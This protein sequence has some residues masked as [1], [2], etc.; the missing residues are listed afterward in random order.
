MEDFQSLLQ[1]SF[2]PSSRGHVGLEREYKTGLSQTTRLIS[3]TDNFEYHKI[4]L[5]GLDSILLAE[6]KKYNQLVEVL[7][8]FN[9]DLGHFQEFRRREY[10]E[11]TKDM[12]KVE[13]DTEVVYED[14]AADTQEFQ[15][16]MHQ[17]DL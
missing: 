5:D 11:M 4:N 15:K 12:V 2:L 16:I 9:H 8:E 3:W 14:K 6:N 17:L 10:S 1:T 13:L 7:R